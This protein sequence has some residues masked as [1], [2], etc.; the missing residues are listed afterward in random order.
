MGFLPPALRQMPREIAVLMDRAALVDECLATPG[1]QG[2][3]EPRAPIG[4]KQDPFHEGTAPAFQVP[5]QGFADLMILRGPLPKAQHALV[6]RQINPQRDDERLA[7]SMKG[8]E[9]QRKGFEVGQ[10]P[11]RGSRD[12]NTARFILGFGGYS[13]DFPMGLSPTPMTRVSAR[14]PCHPGRS[15]FPS[16]VGDHSFPMQPSPRCGGL[17]AHPPTP[18]THAVDSML[19]TIVSCPHSSGPVSCGGTRP[20]PAMPES[21]FAPPRCDL[22]RR[23]VDRSL[24]QH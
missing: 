16:P 4:D 19:D 1:F 6:P 20:V 18:R 17:S 5:Q 23:S 12:R 10:R 9:E 22:V 8:V 13:I 24:G 3:E 14:L 11:F 2:F 21:P 7:S 15:G